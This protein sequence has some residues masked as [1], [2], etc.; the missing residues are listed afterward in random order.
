MEEEL[1]RSARG[2]RK[3]F[4]ATAKEFLTGHNLPDHPEVMGVLIHLPRA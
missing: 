4:P 2:L 1:K 3:L